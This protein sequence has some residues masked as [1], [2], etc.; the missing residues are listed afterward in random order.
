[1]PTEWGDFLLAENPQWAYFS[2]QPFQ[3]GKPAQQQY[4]QGQFGNTWNRYMGEVGRATKAGEEPAS[5][6]NY[7]EDQPFTQQY[8]Q[9]VS[10]Q[11]RGGG[12][13]FNPTTRFVY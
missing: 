12:T 7:L 2:S 3:Q 1:M 8:Y 11:Q 13:R 4:W 6:M 9:N 5:F 10:P